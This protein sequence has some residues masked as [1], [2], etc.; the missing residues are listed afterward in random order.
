MGQL[1]RHAPRAL[2]P[3]RHIPQS[4]AGCERNSVT[5]WGRMEIQIGAPLGTPVGFTDDKHV[6]ALACLGSA[7]KAYAED[8]SVSIDRM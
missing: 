8:L 6:T 1:G 4:E 7:C 5:K 3:S 2:A